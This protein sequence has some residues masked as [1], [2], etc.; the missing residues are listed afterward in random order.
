MI[1]SLYAVDDGLKVI[2]EMVLKTGKKDFFCFLHDILAM[3]FNVIYMVY[4]WVTRWLL[5]VVSE[6]QVIWS[7]SF[8]VIIVFTIC[9]WGKKIFTLQPIAPLLYKISRLQFSFYTR[10]FINDF[11]CTWFTDGLRDGC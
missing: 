7:I 10:Y 9:L 2:Q 5:K 1:Q 8:S 6:I 11:L 3:I 4:L